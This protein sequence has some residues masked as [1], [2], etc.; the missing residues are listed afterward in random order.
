MKK[1]STM[2]DMTDLLLNNIQFSKK[3][4]A[5]TLTRHCYSIIPRFELSS[6]N[7]GP[8]TDT[9]THFVSFISFNISAA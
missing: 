7:R 9:Q 6:A 3:A 2:L 1:H 4:R 5:L 8:H